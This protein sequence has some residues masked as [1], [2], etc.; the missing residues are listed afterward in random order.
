MASEKRD[1]VIAVNFN[2]NIT[3]DQVQVLG[4]TSQS[5]CQ[6]ETFVVYLIKYFPPIQ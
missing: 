1:V 5:L 4:V 3:G 6:D 2:I